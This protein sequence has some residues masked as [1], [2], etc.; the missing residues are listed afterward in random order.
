[1]PRGFSKILLQRQ[2]F[3]IDTGSSPHSVMTK[4]Y[5]VFCVI[6]PIALMLIEVKLNNVD[7][8]KITNLKSEN[9]IAMI[10]KGIASYILTLEI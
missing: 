10:G 8:K 5:T 3:N 1:M 9:Y 6:W 2:I 4:Q 7:I